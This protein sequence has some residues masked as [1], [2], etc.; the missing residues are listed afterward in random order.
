MLERQSDDAILLARLQAL[1]SAPRL[2]MLALLSEGTM[3]A[4]DMARRLQISRPLVTMHLTKLE[5]TGLVASE[6]VLG[7]DGRAY[8][9]FTLADFEVRVDPRIVASMSPDG[10]QA[11]MD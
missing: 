7:P 4:S 10:L 9:Y 5:A 2:R 6:L 3:H 1:A 8:R 11:G